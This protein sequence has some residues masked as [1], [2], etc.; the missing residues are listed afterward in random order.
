MPKTNTINYFKAN[1]NDRND[2]EAKARRHILTKIEK[3]DGLFLKLSGIRT[4]LSGKAIDGKECLAKPSYVVYEHKILLSLSELAKVNYRNFH[5]CPFHSAGCVDNFDEIVQK[6]E[7]V[8]RNKL[9]KRKRRIIR[10]IPSELKELE[11]IPW[12]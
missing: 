7:K 10:V 8:W 2:K 9:N 5:P 12:N 4:R 1:Y 11:I 3:E 6:M